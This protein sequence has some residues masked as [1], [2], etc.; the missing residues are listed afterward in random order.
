M[1]ATKRMEFIARTTLTG[2]AA[3]VS[4]N[5]V[6]SDFRKFFLVGYLVKDGTAD[7]PLLRLNNDSGA[8]YVEEELSVTSTTVAV[9]RKT[10]QTSIELTAN[11]AI[12][13]SDVGLIMI[14]ISKPLAGEVARVTN[15]TSFVDPSLFIW[16]AALAA[17]WSNTAALISRIDILAASGNFAANTTILL[18]GSRD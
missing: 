17:E 2:A 16:Y 18:W 9:E 10:A 12:G 8:N 14:E 4:F 7:E 5:P 15:R 6:P 3:S 1:G 13:A 11:N